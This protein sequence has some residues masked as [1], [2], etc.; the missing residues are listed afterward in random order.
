MAG[1]G[2]WEDDLNQVLVTKP[3]EVVQEACQVLK[4]HGYLV[5]KKLKSELYYSSTL[6][7][8]VFQVLHYANLIVA[9][10]P[11]IGYTMRMRGYRIYTTEGE[12]RGRVFDDPE[13]EIRFLLVHP[14]LSNEINPPKWRS[15]ETTPYRL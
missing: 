6:C 9:H 5:K 13:S 10:A 12:A 4:K 1:K 8:V 2:R 3:A 7:Q 14:Q 15:R 11:S